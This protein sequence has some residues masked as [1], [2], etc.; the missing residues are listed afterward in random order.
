[1]N[2]DEQ[3]DYDVQMESLQNDLKQLFQQE[4]DLKRDVENVF[5]SL[6]YEL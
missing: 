3:I 1:M 6:G 5:K 2:R 4:K